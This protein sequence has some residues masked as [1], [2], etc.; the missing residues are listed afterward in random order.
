MK[1]PSVAVITGFT[2]CAELLERSFAPVAALRRDGLLDRAIYVTWDTPDI[3]PYVAPTS[4]FAAIEVLRVPPPRPT[5]SAAE[6]G[7]IYQTRN[8]EEAL[9]RVDDRALVLKMRPDFVADPNFLHDK[10]RN[11]DGLCGKGTLT[12]P[13][14]VAVPSS[15]FEAKIWL[16]WADANQPFFYED[17]A[18]LG[19]KGDLAKLARTR[20]ESYLGVLAHK[21]C[22]WFAHVLRFAPAFLAG[23]PMFKRYL[24]EFRCYP[25][26]MDYRR[27]LLPVL[28]KEPFFW[29]LLIAHAWVLSSSFHIDAGKQGQ[30]ALYPNTCNP[31]ADWDDFASLRATPPY[32][33]VEEWRSVLRPGEMMSVLSNVY[34]R[35]VDDRWARSLFEA[36]RDMPL[37]SV[38]DVLKSLVHYRRGALA[39]AEASFFKTLFETHDRHWTARAA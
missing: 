4:A 6:R 32:D 1:R 14:N 19:L 36:P 5:G 13:G 29:H 21:E 10:I 31:N 9:N 22:G 38:R 24:Q 7:F 28:S 3:D 12:P 37:E 23:L 2:R 18:F 25:V 27:T 11:F 15:P 20:A 26:D 30:L 16:P 17:A 39:E 34:G 33:K 8:L 35:M